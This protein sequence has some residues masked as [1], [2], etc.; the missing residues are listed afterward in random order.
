MAQISPPHKL[1]KAKIV[2]L[3]T[4]LLSTLAFLQADSAWLQAFK[5]DEFPRVVSGNGKDSLEAEI[6]NKGDAE[7]SS[8]NNSNSNE[9]PRDSCS[10]VLSA[11]S[12]PSWTEDG[13][14]ASFTFSEPATKLL[15]EEIQR[16]L[17]GRRIL[18]VGNSNVRRLTQ[19]L[20]HVAAFFKS[21][22]H[23]ESKRLNLN[24]PSRSKV[25]WNSLKTNFVPPYK[26]YRFM[27]SIF[28]H[29]GWFINSGFD[30][31]ET[32]A[33]AKSEYCPFSLAPS[34]PGGL[35]RTGDAE[36]EGGQWR[37]YLKKNA[38]PEDT[39][40]PRSNNFCDIC[41]LGDGDGDGDVSDRCSP[42]KTLLAYEYVDVSTPAEH[43]GEER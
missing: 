6:K 21:A 33:M 18:L 40:F 12:K 5:R 39:F 27:R 34:D 23:E 22:A 8:S 4:F 2:I 24:L 10:T 19:T 1:N 3:V 16:L 14:T 25:A 31:T 42:S 35:L 29:G 32:R 17:L 13:D 26:K 11:V 41:A 7:T 30:Q 36:K 38:L 20:Y 43:S 28:D 37:N 15:S 9:W